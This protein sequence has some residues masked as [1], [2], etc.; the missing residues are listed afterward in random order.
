MFLHV[1]PVGAPSWDSQRSHAHILSTDACDRGRITLLTQSLRTFATVA[2][3]HYLFT[4]LAHGRSATVAR[5]FCKQ[6]C[7]CL[8]G[9]RSFVNE[10]HWHQKRRNAFAHRIPCTCNVRHSWFAEPPQN[11]GHERDHQDP[12]WKCSPHEFRWALLQG[13]IYMYICIRD[14][15]YMYWFM[16]AYTYIYIYTYTYSSICPP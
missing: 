16:S 15:I 7:T 13:D 2:V 14:Y 12:N 10:L 4:N 11:C 9:S 6:T 3:A 1:V 5:R 8:F